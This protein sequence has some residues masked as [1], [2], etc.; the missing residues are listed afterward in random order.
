M[1]A[2]EGRVG[3][4]FVLRLEDGD[5]IPS[6]IEN[7]ARERGVQAAFCAL[8]GGVGSG[9]LVVGPERGDALPVTPLHRLI[10]APHEAAAVGTIFPGEDGA[11]RLHMHACLGREGSSTTGCVRPG[12]QV[13]K[14][15]EVVVL[16]LLEVD[17]KR[18]MDPAAGLEVLSV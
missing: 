2:V 16:E 5:A 8:L 18:R 3:R 7:F 9:R 12:I 10:D 1:K 11:P 4:L 6:C 15:A 17:L 13:W 14:V